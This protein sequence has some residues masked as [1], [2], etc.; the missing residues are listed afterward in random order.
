MGAT[1]ARG[2]CPI[3]R[4]D[5]WVPVSELLGEKQC[6]RCS[7]ELWAIGFSRGTVFFPRRQVESLADL[8]SVLAGSAIGADASEIEA[9]L[10]G[11]DEFDVAEMLWEV[12]EALREQGN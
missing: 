2:C 7:V 9:A 10:Q 8:L 6:P 11:A 1:G 12:E 5:L 3:C 4:A